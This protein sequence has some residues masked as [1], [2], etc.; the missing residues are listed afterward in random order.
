MSNALD[1]IHRVLSV[2]DDDPFS[3]LLDSALDF[4]LTLGTCKTP[5]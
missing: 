3:G 2:P 5:H 4:K 1:V